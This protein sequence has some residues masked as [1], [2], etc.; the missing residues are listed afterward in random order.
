MRNLAI[1]LTVWTVLWFG[2]IGTLVGCEYKAH[3][4]VSTSLVPSNNNVY[5]DSAYADLAQAFNEKKLMVDTLQRKC[6]SLKY[7]TD[8]LNIELFN[9]GYKVE[10]VKNY[11]KIVK[12]NPS[13]MKFFLGW[14]DRAVR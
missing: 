9:E 2:L 14:V 1:Q 6:D 5:T 3:Q 11:I 13:Q 7:L 10:N 8:S 4:P 12:H